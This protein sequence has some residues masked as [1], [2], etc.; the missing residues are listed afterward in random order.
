MHIRHWAVSHHG[1]ART[2]RPTLRC[3]RQRDLPVRLRLAGADPIGELD[4]S[5][6]AAHPAAGQPGPYIDPAVTASLVA[7]AA[8][9]GFD[10]TKL[11]QLISE[12]NDNYSR[13]NAYA[14]H[15]LL[16]AL[17][18][19]VPP[20]LGCTDFKAAANN[21]HWGRTDRNYARRLTDFSC[22]PDARFWDPMLGLLI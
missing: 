4:S 6:Q 15:A 12:L 10:P 14:V 21:Y 22:E 11:T 18:D 17:L 1:I 8:A 7:R 20:M 13:G 5:G 3:L 9:L 2:T 16:R 19:H